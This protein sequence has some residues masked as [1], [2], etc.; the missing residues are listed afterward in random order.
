MLVLQVVTISNIDSSVTSLALS[1]DGE[2]LLTNLRSHVGQLWHIRPYLD[3]VFMFLETISDQ[4]I[5]V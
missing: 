3:Q 2:W 4:G 5:R 1:R